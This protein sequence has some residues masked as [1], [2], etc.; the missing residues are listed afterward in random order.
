M[1]F[2][3]MTFSCNYV[4]EGNFVNGLEMQKNVRSAS[5]KL[6]TATGKHCGKEFNKIISQITSSKH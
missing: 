1:S 2:T 6:Y 3:P 5:L 4:Q